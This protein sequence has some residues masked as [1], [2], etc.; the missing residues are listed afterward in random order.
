MEVMK[1][2]KK[3]KKKLDDRNEISETLKYLN[4]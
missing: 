3:K 1:C 4:K 2:Q